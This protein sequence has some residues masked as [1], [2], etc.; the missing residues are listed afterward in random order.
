MF[1]CF[2]FRFSRGLRRLLLI[3]QV[4]RRISR[5]GLSSDASFVIQAQWQS[6]FSNSAVIYG[7]LLT[8][9]YSGIAP[10]ENPFDKLGTA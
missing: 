3:S 5:P 9:G 6:R 10:Q 4:P 1:A 7:E 2:Y 8:E